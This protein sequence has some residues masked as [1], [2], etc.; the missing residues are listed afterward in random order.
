MHGMP[1]CGERKFFLQSST[2]R[3]C[4][5]ESSSNSKDA[6]VPRAFLLELPSNS[7]RRTFSYTRQMTF[8]VSWKSRN[9]SGSD[10]VLSDAV[11]Q[12]ILSVVINISVQIECTPLSKEHSLSIVY[13]TN[14]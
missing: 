11:L 2:W 10:D 9:T 7:M 8:F 14:L 5:F 1:C 4:D 3:V 13:I 6:M 12:K